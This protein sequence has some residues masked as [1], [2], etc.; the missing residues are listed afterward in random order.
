M[1]LFLKHLYLIAFTSLLLAACDVI[2]PPYITD[3]ATNDNMDNPEVV[4]KFLL[5]E[6]TGHNCPNCPFGSDM[7]KTLQA[8]YGDRLIV[9]SVHAGFFAMPIPPTFV[10]DFRTPEGNALNSYFGVAG[11]PIGMVNRVEFEGD[12]LMGPNA[13]GSAMAALANDDPVVALSLGLTMQ[14][15]NSFRLSVEMDALTDLPGEFYLVAVVTED[16]I[17]SPQKINDPDY[18]DGYIPEYVHNYVLRRGI[19]DIW[20]DKLND[21]RVERGE[22][23]ERTYDFSMDDSWMTESC[24]VVVWIMNE[25]LEVLQVERV[26]FS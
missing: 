26:T 15:G 7:A 5:E 24:A 19:T 9:V 23:F 25:Q 6:F 11:N 18:P 3:Q 2:E 1:R 10:N 8:F 4:Q 17:I 13:W 16:G 12:R 21:E 20:G 22:R 14:P